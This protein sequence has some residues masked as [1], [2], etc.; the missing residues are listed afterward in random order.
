MII[1]KFNT[2]VIY[3]PIKIGIL[4]ATIYFWAW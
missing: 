2:L 1:K 3:L 4:A